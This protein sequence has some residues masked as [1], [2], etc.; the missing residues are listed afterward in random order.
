[1]HCL[2]CKKSHNLGHIIHGYPCISPSSLAFHYKEGNVQNSKTPEGPYYFYSDSR[3]KN[4]NMSE[5][6]Q[7]T[8]P[9]KV[10]SDCEQ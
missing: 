9:T 5:E 8:D 10:L 7:E 2:D 6:K 4:M 1:M 3:K